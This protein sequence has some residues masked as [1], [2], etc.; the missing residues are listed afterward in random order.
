MRGKEALQNV[1]GE[2]KIPIKKKLE[3]NYQAAKDVGLFTKFSQK[4]VDSIESIMAKCNLY[5]LTREQAAY[6]L[7]TAYHEAYN[8]KVANSR[9]TPIEEFGGESYLKSKPYYPYYGR[10]FVQ[11]TW[12][13]NYDK[14]GKRLNLDLVG[15]PELAL[16][17]HIAADI[18]VHGML[19]GEFTGKK[20]TDYVNSE[21][22]DYH[23]ARRIINGMDRADLIASYAVRMEICIK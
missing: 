15:C 3:F 16:T 17:T 4:Q 11:L 10:G 9:I 2:S 5:G 22:K 6:T 20:L 12:E 1:K 8:P 7:A 21:K 23:N 13:R 19:H 14:Q 18:L